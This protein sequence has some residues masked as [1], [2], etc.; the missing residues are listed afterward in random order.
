M[1]LVA[2]VVRVVG[3]GNQVFSAAFLECL[4]GGFILIRVQ[5]ILMLSGNG[6]GGR[7]CWE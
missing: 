6:A 4:R 5:L 3:A 7:F 1:E 2:F